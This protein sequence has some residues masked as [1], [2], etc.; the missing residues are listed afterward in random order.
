MKTLSQDL[1]SF[2]QQYAY[3]EKPLYVELNKTPYPLGKKCSSYNHYVY[4]STDLSQQKKINRVYT[5]FAFKRVVLCEFLD[6]TT[7]FSCGYNWF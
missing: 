2:A 5:G 6:I 4:Y 7:G 3:A 1:T